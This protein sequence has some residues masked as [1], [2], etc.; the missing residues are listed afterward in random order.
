MFYK[1][2]LFFGQSNILHEIYGFFFAN[3]A[4]NAAMIT[5]F[6]ASNSNIAKV[7]RQH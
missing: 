7:H 4:N 2:P 5:T 3:S 1:V 6:N